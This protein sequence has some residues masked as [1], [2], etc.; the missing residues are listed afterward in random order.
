MRLR[1]A[2][3]A[4]SDP[5]DKKSWSGILYYMLLALQ[6]HCGNV[7]FLTS[8]TSQIPINIGGMFSLISRKTINKR[9]DYYH[10][11][12]LAK[13]YARSFNKKLKSHNYD[14][15]FTV[16]SS[17]LCAYLKTNIP[18]ILCPDST[19]YCKLNYYP[20]YTNLYNFSVTHGKMLEQKAF[21]NANA[22]IFPSQWAA[23]SA[24]NNFNI[25]IGKTFVIP[26][27]A[28]L[29]TVPLEN[30]FG[31]PNNSGVCRLL[32]IG[33]EWERKGGLIAF[34]T[35][36]KLEKM[37]IKSELTICGCLPPPF[38]K[39]ENLRIVPYLDKTKLDQYK[40]LT[41]LY[42]NS[43]FLLLPTRAEFFGIVFSEASAFG[44]PSITTK[45]G[46]VSSAIENGING[47]LLS[48]EAGA[49]EYAKKIYEIF[50]NK[51]VFY[52]LKKSC[53]KR[54]DEKLNWDH[55]GNKVNHIINEMLFN[56]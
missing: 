30:D 38:I 40:Q 52:D 43:D 4:S 10:S 42:S 16:P 28:N 13:S 49:D 24:I 31:S 36:L 19:Y 39:H 22:L 50:T 32:F 53:R 34:E 15:I 37:G 23:D 21:Q 11:I 26:M 33:T 2:F 56:K 48:Q 47:Y 5:T 27:G 55:W 3:L 12:W 1:I 44:L 46:G 7:E 20:L 45:T 41:E 25:P 9:F 35:L 8:L 6:R 54:F 17:T 18:I 29:E 14:L 51:E